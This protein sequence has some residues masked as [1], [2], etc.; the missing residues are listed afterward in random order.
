MIQSNT[1]AFILG[2]EWRLSLAELI[3]VFGHDSLR[4]QNEQIAIFSVE[5]PLQRDVIN[6]LGGTIRIIRIIGETDEKKF[7]TDA[8]EL[9]A[10]IFKDKKAQF[11]LGAYG[12]DLP[13]E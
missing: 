5:K 9:I 4:S 8:L 2:R 11:A 3:H 13:L 10:K 1:Y 12:A 7:P 6:R